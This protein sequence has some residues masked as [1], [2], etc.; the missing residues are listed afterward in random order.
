M[1]NVVKLVKCETISAT[2]AQSDTR[3][4]DRSSVV[5]PGISSSLSS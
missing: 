5:T 3:F 4:R 1:T 2:F